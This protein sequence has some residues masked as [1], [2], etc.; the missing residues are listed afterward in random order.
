MHRRGILA[1]MDRN[2][3]STG[4][5]RTYDSSG[6]RRAAEQRR[7]HVATV[8][9]ELFA[10]HGW[11]GT[12][13]AGVAKGAGVSP[14]LVQ[15]TFGGKA[16]LLMTAFR[17]ASFDRDV[18]TREL[19][20]D[21]HLDDEPDREVRLEAIVELSCRAL[22]P[23][24]PLVPVLLHAAAQDDTVRALYQ[25]ARHH[26][27]QAAHDIVE[28]LAPGPVPADAVDEVTV[29]ILPQTY[30]VFTQDLGWTTDRYAAWLHRGFQRAVAPVPPGARAES[31]SRTS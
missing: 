29:M 10:T 20:A 24:A 7:Q 2:T 3:A 18:N 17:Q 6:R 12:T 13:I 31:R 22:A 28:L 27:R 4:T 21:L 19:L 25:Q 26:H 1:R 16:G 23:T 14:E 11:V 9:A 15:R 5:G 8:A 30:L